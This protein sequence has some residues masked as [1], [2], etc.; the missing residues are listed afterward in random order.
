V[1]VLRRSRQVVNRTE[2]LTT[3]WGYFLCKDRNDEGILDSRLKRYRIQTGVEKKAIG[4]KESVLREC[5]D[6]IL[7]VFKN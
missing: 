1:K 2:G 4:S 6:V 5:L 7:L 3:G